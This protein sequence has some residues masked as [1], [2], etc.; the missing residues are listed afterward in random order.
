MMN[1]LAVSRKDKL[2]YSDKRSKYINEYVAGIRIVKYYGWESMVEN[3][4]SE[5]RDKEG[6][7]IL[8]SAIY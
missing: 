7:Y 6:K 3:G 2:S 1:R 8:K 4:I 5:C